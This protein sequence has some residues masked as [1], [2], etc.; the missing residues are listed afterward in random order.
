MIKLISKMIK[1]Q[2]FIQYKY[3]YFNLFIKQGLIYTYGV[4]GFMTSISVLIGK[5]IREIRE[6]KHIK[7][8]ELANMID[9][10]PTNLSKIEK[11]IHF[12]KDETIQKIITA[13]DI[14]IKAL[15]DVRHI[16]DKEILT[17]KINKA[18]AN[19]TN[20]ELQFF[21]RMISAYYE[22]KLK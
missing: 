14:D 7:Q 5:R 11:G 10:E 17:K 3:M 2:S 16:E 21:Y 9:I 1:N 8:V 22:T 4:G 18:L 12:P 19:A 6:S 15:F 20:L 13:L